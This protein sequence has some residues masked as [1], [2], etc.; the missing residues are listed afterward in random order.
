MAVACGTRPG[1]ASHRA[2]ASRCGRLRRGKRPYARHDP[3]PCG[4][5]EAAAAEAAAAAATG[6]PPARRRGQRG[7]GGPRR[8]SGLSRTPTPPS[9]TSPTR[10]SR[11][12]PAG[13]GPG[14]ERSAAASGPARP[15]PCARRRPALVPSD[16]PLAALWH[17][18][19]GIGAAATA[20]ERASGV[21]Q[22]QKGALARP[23]GEVGAQPGRPPDFDHKAESDH[24]AEIEP[25][26]EFEETAGWTHASIDDG[27]EGASPRPVRSRLDR[28][29]PCFTGGRRTAIVY[30][31]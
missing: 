29:R 24:K 31:W 30:R 3:E 2:P 25:T 8:R 16:G 17:A 22:G 5:P 18:G 23:G 27:L 28:S 19:L 26:A 20:E 13:A 9:P 1:L 10:T 6:A 7:G 21:R 12:R 15:P 11:V 4:T 14:C